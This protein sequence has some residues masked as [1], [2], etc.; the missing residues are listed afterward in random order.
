[1]CAKATASKSAKGFEESL[2][3]ASNKLRGSWGMF[4]QSLKFTRNHHDNTKH[5]SVY[6]QDVSVT[7]YKLAKM[8]LAAGRSRQSVRN[9]G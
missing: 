3:D 9:T 1:M 8:N 7:T 4:V 5:I 6:E 2:W